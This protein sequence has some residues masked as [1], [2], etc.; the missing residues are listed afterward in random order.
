MMG[1]L[2]PEAKHFDPLMIIGTSSSEAT[3]RK[4]H[5]HAM[6]K[7]FRLSLN[8]LGNRKIGP[9]AGLVD[10]V[11]Q[12]SPRNL[13]E[14]RSACHFVLALVSEGWVTLFQQGGPAG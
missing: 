13:P 9:W 11:D 6:P 2:R 10:L 4:E 7:E 12:P 3:A 8:H 5:V 1:W 14:L